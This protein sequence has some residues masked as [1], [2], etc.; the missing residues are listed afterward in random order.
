M[1]E[2]IRARA[3]ERRILRALGKGA[4]PELLE[5][6]MK[7]AFGGF[8]R[9]DSQQSSVPRKGTEGMLKAYSDMPWLRAAAQKVGD[10][11]AST[12]WTLG[13]LQGSGDSADAGRVLGEWDRPTG[14]TRRLQ[15]MEPKL[16]R[17][18]IAG[19]RK[20]GDFV[21]VE[22]HPL[23]DL[24]E[25]GNEFRDGRS[26]FKVTTLQYDLVGES[27]W[28]KERNAGRVE[29]VWPVPPTWIDR[30]PLP[31][32]A[33]PSFDIK[34]N[35]RT[36]RL[37]ASEVIWFADPD[38][39]QPYARGTGTARSL[40]DELDTDEMAAKFTRSFF[41]NSARPDLLIFGEGLTEPDVKRL[42]IEWN[43]K[44]RGW[45]R[46][47]SAH[48]LNRKVEVKELSRSLKELEFTELRKFERDTMVSVW[49]LPPEM[50]GILQSSNR[51]T[52]DAAD[53]LF[54][55]WVLVPRLEAIRM[56]LQERLVPDFDGRLILDYVSPVQ[57]DRAMQ[58]EAAKAAP[59]SLM[60]DEWRE[61]SGHAELEDDRGKVHPVPMG[62][63][64]LRS[65]EL[66]SG[67]AAPEDDDE[68]LD[69]VDD[70]DERA[71]EPGEVTHV[72]SHLRLIG[73]DL[74]KA[75]VPIEPIVSA[76][77]ADELVRQMTPELLATAESFGN[78]MM[79]EI[80]GGITFNVLD[81][82]VD[83]Y[84]TA[85]G[86]EKIKR[87]NGTTKSLVRRTLAEG[88]REGESINALAD[89]IESVFEAAQ[90]HRSVVIAR[91]EVQ[92]AANFAKD[93]ALRQARVPLKQWL[94]TRGPRVRESH[95][96][97]VG[98]DGQV[99]A[100][101]G[102]FRSPITGAQGPHPGRMGRADEDIQC[103]C[104]VLAVFEDD[105][106]NRRTIAETE[107]Q[108]L[109][110]WRSFVRRRLEHDKRMRVAV[111][112]GFASQLTRALEALRRMEAA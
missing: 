11:I 97:E 87:A 73:P 102:E 42:K 33:E 93:E 53:F 3:A 81:P 19:L 50:L 61:L 85:I 63:Q 62:I 105:D 72:G 55:K 99:V 54:G 94:S 37:P 83:G 7:D 66:A 60:L 110:A 70:E 6:M 104:T 18:R 46:A 32:D 95:Q 64:F 10:S 68:D 82:N 100:Q 71:L 107:E 51:A 69:L 35:N 14:R 106:G 111:R 5:A 112:R 84:I 31:G 27:F 45:A 15:R 26:V 48:F 90:G 101:A 75:S 47:F 76:I 78:D 65:E 40:A 38:P 43:Q 34:L 109:I 25:A 24:L 44:L 17:E 23:L 77:Q 9:F 20:Q 41:Q 57:E 89:R 96:P 1:F 59:W 52:I 30:T 28:I 79:D 56:T 91:T 22:D 103:R 92:S 80:G 12:T 8:V 67:S 16:R 86:A 58:L 39:N 36:A 2:G 29:G 108:K 74:T 49:G 4:T 21:E 88:V 13:F 98:L